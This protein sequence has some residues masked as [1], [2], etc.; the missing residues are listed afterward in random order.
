MRTLEQALANA[1]RIRGEIPHLIQPE[2]TA[3]DMVL[4]ADRISDLEEAMQRIKDWADAYPLDMFPEPN[5]PHVHEVLLKEGMSLDRISASNMRHV[6][7][8]MGLIARQ[9]LKTRV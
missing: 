1:E 8:G 6:A 5:W 9:A 3:F 7:R 4:L 2:N